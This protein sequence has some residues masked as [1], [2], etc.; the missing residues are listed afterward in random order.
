MAQNRWIIPTDIF[1]V[2]VSSVDQFPAPIQVDIT[3]PDAVFYDPDGEYDEI[4]IEFDNPVYSSLYGMGDD[5]GQDFILQPTDNILQGKII[6]DEEGIRAAADH[7]TFY[8]DL[9]VKG[10]K[11]GSNTEIELDRK[12]F[13]FELIA[14]DHGELYIVMENDDN[15]FEWI[16]G[17]TP[18]YKEVEIYSLD[19][20]RIQVPKEF[21]TENPLPGKDFRNSTPEYDVFIIDESAHDFDNPFLFKIRP[22]LSAFDEPDFIEDKFESIYQ[23]MA[24]FLNS[25]SNY[26]QD[27]E[28]RI[29]DDGASYANRELYSYFAIRDIQPA[30]PLPLRLKSSYL[31]NVTFPDFIDHEDIT[32]E[33]AIEIRD[34]H[35]VEANTLPVGVYADFIEV[36]VIGGDDFTIPVN[37]KIVDQVE[38]GYSSTGVNFTKDNI[39]T[40]FYDNKERMMLSYST[41]VK[42]LLFFGDFTPDL[43]FDYKNGYFD[44][45]SVILMGTI[46]DRLYPR[47]TTREIEHIFFNSLLMNPSGIEL[48][49]YEAPLQV[50]LNYQSI[51]MDDDSTGVRVVDSQTRWMRGRSPLNYENGSRLLANRERNI[52]ITPN[53]FILANYHRANTPDFEIRVYQNENLIKTVSVD[54]RKETFGVLLSCED[55][56]P[57]DVIE[58]KQFYMRLVDDMWEEIGQNG[59]VQK[60]YVFPKG[61]QTNTLIYLSEYGKP[62]LF[63]FTG[64][65]GYSTEYDHNTEKSLN[66]SVEEIRNLDT[67]RNQSII[68]NTGYLLKGNDVVIDE[69]LRAEKA[70]LLDRA[71]G[72]FIELRPKTEKLANTDSDTDTYSYDIEFDIIPE[73]DAEVYN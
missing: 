53:S 12:R 18:D 39:E 8:I 6:F 61:K 26:F 55:F 48:L 29:I 70:W 19:P 2:V 65:F 27:L 50:E 37:Y 71:H 52:R 34:L 35:P 9:Y 66:L 16:F 57:G 44:N 22:D 46:I 31:M 68:M 42:P 15:L 17:D 60:Y 47:L 20:F 40:I 41:L 54:R 45:Q 14:I 11:T 56:T 69:I 23:L 64:G 10:R 4:K 51:N 1:R 32:G 62:E 13:S 59:I 30:E 21:E 5:F 72:R 58:L 63:E 43:E 28:V 3:V 24:S 38:K 49:Q 36:E 67:S 7:Y 33:T 73:N 25:D